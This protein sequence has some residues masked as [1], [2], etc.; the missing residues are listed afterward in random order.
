MKRESLPLR[1]D[2]D[3]LRIAR[4]RSSTNLSAKRRKE[5][6]KITQPVFRTFFSGAPCQQNRIPQYQSR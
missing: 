4:S 1:Y 2:Y 6:N 3:L 5:P